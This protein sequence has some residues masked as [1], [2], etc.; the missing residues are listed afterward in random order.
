M[1][2]WK[3]KK[4]LPGHPTDLAIDVRADAGADRREARARRGDAAGD[5]RVDRAGLRGGRRE[6]RISRPREPGALRGPRR[7]R[8]PTR[9]PATTPC[10]TARAA[11]SR[12]SSRAATTPIFFRQRPPEGHEEA[13]RTPG[14]RGAPVA[15]VLRRERLKGPGLS[16]VYVHDELPGRELEKI[17]RVPGRGRAPLR[18]AL[19]GRWRADRRSTSASRRG[20]SSSPASP[21]C[22]EAR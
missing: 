4:L 19:F 11:P 1:V 7:G 22:T 15:L 2:L 21:P 20:P 16:A 14:P 5:G 12:S 8:S 13:T 9:R 10:C 6:G 3:L 18:Q 17:A